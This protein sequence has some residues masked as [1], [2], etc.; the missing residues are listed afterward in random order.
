MS[1]I[2]FFFVCICTHV[3]SANIY[4]SIYS[5]S[6][7]VAIKKM[8]QMD[9]AITLCSANYAH[10]IFLLL[11]NT[12][13]GGGGEIR[14]LYRPSALEALKVCFGTVILPLGAERAV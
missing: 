7:V 2:Q 6:V 12:R 5:L 4:S 3:I 9:S 11:K 8:M 10:A 13:T 14:A 1:S